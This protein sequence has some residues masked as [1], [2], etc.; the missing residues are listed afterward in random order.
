MKII[1][2][3]TKSKLK[4]GHKVYDCALGKNGTVAFENG[5]EGD[6]KTPLGIYQLRYGF[7]RADRVE[8]P[9]TTLQMH[10]MSKTD[11]WCDAPGDL[12]YNR[13]VRLPYP[14][15]T[16]KLYRDSHVYDIIIVLGHNDSPPTPG[17]G[18][19]IFLHVAR[20][21]Y[22]PTQGCV[23]VTQEDMLALLP[24]LSNKSLIEIT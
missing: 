6:G 5:K 16:E 24:N 3:T 7:Y 21:N 8:L 11:G 20:E 22:G 17:L 9:E 4:L 1:V 18:S 12:A 15:S 13:P 19:A 23:A 2:D 10:A 14:A